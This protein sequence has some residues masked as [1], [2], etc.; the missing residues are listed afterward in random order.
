MKNINIKMVAIVL[1]VVVLAVAGGFV[2]YKKVYKNMSSLKNPMVAQITSQQIKTKVW[3]DPMGFKFDYPYDMTVNPHNEDKDNYAHVELAAT[4]SAGSIIVW[5]KDTNYSTLDDWVKGDKTVAGGSA[6]DTTW[7]GQTAKKVAIAGDNPRVE[8]GVL[9]DGLLW[10]LDGI[11]DKDNKF[12]R[13]YD[14][15]LTNFKFYSIGGTTVQNGGDNSSSPSVD[16]SS[17]GGDSGGDE[18]VVE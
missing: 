3:T 11:P 5:A 18:E 4:G 15:I 7:G 17:A 9:Y 12:T 14:D 1:L 8:T 10:I 6:L 13:A 16:N 2:W